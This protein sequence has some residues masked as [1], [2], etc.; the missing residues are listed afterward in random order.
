[1]YRRLQDPSSSSLSSHPAADTAVPSSEAEPIP[2][3]PQGC[4]LEAEK[5]EVRPTLMVSYPGSGAK[6][7]WKLIRGMTGMMTGA[8]HDNNGLVADGRALVVKTHYPVQ[9]DE[10]SQQR[11]DTVK[12]IDRAILLLRNP[13][14]AIPSMH[15]FEYEQTHNLPNHSTRAPLKEW[16]PWRDAWFATELEKWERLARHW[17]ERYG[18]PGSDRL[19][20]VTF[21][22]L[23]SKEP[24]VSVVEMKRIGN[25]L[26][27]GDERVTTVPDDQIQCVWETIMTDKQVGYEGKR[28][29]SLRHGPKVNYPFT[30]EQLNEMGR[31][32]QRL[33]DWRPDHLG[34]IMDGYIKAIQEEK[35]IDGGTAIAAETEGDKF[36]NEV[37]RERT[38]ESVVAVATTIEAG[39]TEA[40]THVKTGMQ[41]EPKVKTP[42]N[43]GVPVGKASA[44]HDN[45]GLPIMKAP[46]SW[47][48]KFTW[49]K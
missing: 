20:N 14:H 47:K 16:F 9:D 27:Q 18:N 31:M 26:R 3:N 5:R 25:F 49:K 36:G 29:H 32:L 40:A 39:E 8:D 30:S 17:V 12:H 48:P 46:S 22:A 2:P 4:V 21:E 6:M 7:T 1:M 11:F 33:A 19:L 38:V 24:G 37:G 10:E 28:R 44:K 35:N 15:N 34:A 41:E 43:A 45:A 42:A 23:T 13:L